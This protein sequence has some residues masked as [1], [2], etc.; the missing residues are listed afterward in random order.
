MDNINVDSYEPLTPPSVVRNI[1]P[2]TQKIIDLVEETRD[3]I[4]DIISGVSS[5]KLFIVGPCSIHNVDDALEY[6]RLLKNIAD[7][8]SDRILIVMRVYFEKPRTT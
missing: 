3:E 6:G 5:K 7:K 4:K 1:I 8:V 2:T